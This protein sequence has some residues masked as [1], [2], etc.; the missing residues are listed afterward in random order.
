MLRGLRPPI[1]ICAAV[2]GVFSLTECLVEKMR[3]ED[4]ESSYVNTAVAGAA[5]GMAMGSAT[6][7]ID[8]MAISALSL[9]VFMGMVGYNGLRT[10]SDPEHANTKWHKLRPFK[11]EESST[12]TELKEK[13]PEFKDW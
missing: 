6:M 12:V 13:Y 2:C 5:A 9:G 7:R 11:E 4:R 8:I 3:D 10:T 1:A